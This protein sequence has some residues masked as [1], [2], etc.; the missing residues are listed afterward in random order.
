M[1][2]IEEHKRR[3]AEMVK[4][5]EEKVKNDLIVER[6][7]IVGFAA[8]EAACDLLAILLHR[9]NL[10]TPGF[11]V[12]HR[13]FASPQL[14]QKKYAFDFPHKSELVGLLVNQE[15]Y[16]SLLCYGKAKERP[17]VE[18]AVKNFFAIKQVVEE[19]VGEPL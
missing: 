1:V 6:Q 13:F 17:V 11:A 4:D 12:N 14:A 15:K 10:I 18:A 7:E 19:V 16:R 8:S 3:A 9:R 5:V 2:S